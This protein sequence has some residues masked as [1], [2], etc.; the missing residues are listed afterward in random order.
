MKKTAPCLLHPFPPTACF[1]YAS[2][3]PSASCRPYAKG[4]F[5]V[6]PALC[7]SASRLMHKKTA[8]LKTT[9][10]FTL[11]IM[12]YLSILFVCFFAVQP[13]LFMLIDLYNPAVL[14]YN[15]YRPIS[16]RLD[17]RLYLEKI[18]FRYFAFLHFPQPASLFLNK[19]WSRVISVSCIRKQRNYCLA[20]VFRTLCKLNSSM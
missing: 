8:A 2:R 4:V 6:R 14:Y 11:S 7:T 18:R 9:P 20:F 15:I 10:L 3:F 5:P 17:K 19:Q 1:P 16:Y 12:F 13:D